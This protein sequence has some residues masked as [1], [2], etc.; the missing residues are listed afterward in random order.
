MN[1]LV[2]VKIQYQEEIRRFSCEPVF[3]LLEQTVRTLFCI[4]DTVS[5][6]LKY[7][8]EDGDLCTISTQLELDY[9]VSHV[10]PL[11]LKV[12]SKAVQSLPPC[13]G[14]PLCRT[15]TEGSNFVLMTKEK[16]IQNKLLGIKALL[17][18]PGLP[19]QRVENLMKRRQILES[20]LNALS[21]P[22]GVPVV[23]DGDSSPTVSEFAPGWRGRGCGRRGRGAFGS[24]HGNRE[25][26]WRN[27]NPELQGFHQEIFSLKTDLR[28]KKMAYLTAKQNGAPESEVAALFHDLELAR[29]ALDAKKAAKMQLKDASGNS[30]DGHPCATGMFGRGRGRGRGACFGQKWR[31]ENPQAEQ[32]REEIRALKEVVGA[33]RIALQNAKRNDAP[34]SE[35]ELLFQDF[36]GA[37]NDLMQ[38]K[39]AKREAK[40]AF[41][42]NQVGLGEAPVG[43]VNSEQIPCHFKSRRHAQPQMQEMMQEIFALKSIVVEKKLALQDARTKGAPQPEIERLFS[44]F[45]VAR[46]NLRQKKA[47][48]RE[49]KDTLFTSQTL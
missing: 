39:I 15:S 9:A 47:F 4:A 19:P 6:V 32:M 8:D 12:I 5:Y 26:C 18:Q 21:S 17:E 2:H 40:V 10:T 44:D 13:D 31:Q 20:R 22:P 46:N 35:I 25:N 49:M 30:I 28:S 1:T 45:V 14:V 29:N 48:R 36:I 11:R 33:K 24:D 41:V 23:P 37:R 42:R 3:S 43:D 7:T 38:K 16:M 34:K 27:R